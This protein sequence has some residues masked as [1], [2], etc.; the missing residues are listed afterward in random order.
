MIFGMAEQGTQRNLLA[1]VLAL[2][3]DFVRPEDLVA[4]LRKWSETKAEPVADI[5]VTNGQL[6]ARRRDLLLG[7]VDEHLKQHDND[8]AQC[9]AALSVSESLRDDLLQIADPELA[10]SLTRLKFTSKEPEF[11]P[12]TTQHFAPPAT[13]VPAQ[14]TD[15]D[16]PFSTRMVSA[17]EAKAAAKAIRESSKSRTADR[18]RVLRMH[19]KGGLGLVSVAVDGE[20]HREVALKE[21]QRQHAD[22]VSSRSRFLVEAEITGRLEHPGIVPVYGLGQYPDGRPYYAM[23]FIRGKSMR[24]AIDEFHN[25]SPD[26]VLDDGERQLEFRHLLGNFIAVCNTME[27]AH[28]RGILHR[29]LKPDNVMLGDYGETLVVD[30]GLAKA[31]GQAELADEGE[32]SKI[33]PRS[34]GTSETLPGSAIGTPQY[35]SPEQA[36]GKLDEMTAASDIYSLG[37]TLYQLITGSTM[38][39]RISLMEILRRV[40]KGEFTPPCERKKDVPLALNAICLKALALKP[41]DRYA[42]ARDLAVDVEHWLADEPVSVYKEP[43]SQRVARWARRHRSAAMATVVSLGVISIVAIIASLVIEGA[44]QRE[45]AAKVR[46]QTAKVEAT[47]RSRQAREVIDTLLTGVGQALENYPGMQ[48]ARKRLLQRAADD[49]LQLTDAT[50]TDPDLRAEAA[51]AFSRLG[52][53]RS[54]LNQLDDADKAYRSAE[55]M[56]TEL[57]DQYPTRVDFQTELGNC[58]TRRGLANVTRGRGE[59]AETAYKQALAVLEP[60]TKSNPQDSD[61]GDALGT[62]LVNLGRLQADRN[63]PQDAEATLHRAVSVFEKLTSTESAKPRLRNA[64]AAARNAVGKF[65][66]TLGREQDAIA[67]F[68]EAIKAFNQLVSTHPGEAEYLSARAATRLHLAAAFRDAGRYDD[69][70]TAYRRAVEDYETLLEALPDVPRYRENLSVARTDLGQVLHKLGQNPAALVELKKSFAEFETLANE[71]PSVPSYLEGVA[72]TGTT[73]SSV[74]RE[75]GKFDEAKADVEL[76]IGFYRQLVESLPDVLRYRAELGVA[77]AHQSRILARLSMTAETEQAFQA[78]VSELQTAIKAV[79]HDPHYREDLAHAFAHWAWHK[80]QTGDMSGCRDAQQQALQ[81]FDGL[82]SD[83]PETARLADGAAWL[84]TTG[85]IVELRDLPRAKS[86]ATRATELVPLNDFFWRTLGAA[87]FQSK[88]DDAARTSLKKA[89]D[90]R[91]SEAGIAVFLLSLTEQRLGNAE[92]ARRLFDAAVNWTEANKPGD[93]ET[94]RYREQTAAALAI[95]TTNQ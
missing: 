16:D 30:W 68:Q 31:M 4:A 80:Q 47:T 27:Y 10:A 32:G 5:L 37:A 53:V 76:A 61:A 23:R 44:R 79:P 34:S 57:I 33:I 13:V 9:L 15:D 66:I 2:Q 35:M 78:A 7:L 26:K 62:V 83:F 58:L 77:L 92:E 12:Y 94:Q 72:A 25:P 8:T 48:E 29:D 59:D 88:E 20:L 86:L 6:D 38:F 54:I 17:E 85:P 41:T 89:F 51:R 64:L 11:D 93:E 14:T 75:L 40:Q 19:A 55:A 74:Q 65:L 70:V 52:D 82:L 24:K 45:S 95:K 3:L 22:N 73:L 42:T 71:F 90:L 84:L 50:S 1:G 49:Y 63:K 67:T 21:I 46:E 18:Y 43:L 87:Q 36:A 81:V 91:P 60:V 28:C 69:E 39:E 56:W